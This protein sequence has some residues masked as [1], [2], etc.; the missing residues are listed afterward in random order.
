MWLHIETALRAAMAGIDPARVTPGEPVTSANAVLPHVPIYG[1]TDGP[2][3]EDETGAYIQIAWLGY[4]VADQAHL[5]TAVMLDLLY[6]IRIGCGA[7]VIDPDTLRTLDTGLTEALHR[8]LD[9]ALDP[10]S[11]AP[12]RPRLIDPPPPQWQGAAGEMALYFT[13]RQTHKGANHHG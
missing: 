2:S 4:T 13:L 11:P 5:R 8:L 3:L 10:A 7:A 12:N 6:V 1:T 9:F